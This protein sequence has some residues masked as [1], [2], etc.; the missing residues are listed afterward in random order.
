MTMNKKAVQLSINFIVITI[1]SLLVLGVGFYV[2]TNI[3]TTAYEYQDKLNEQTKEATLAALRQSGELVSLPLNKY[4]IKRGEMDQ[5]AIGLLNNAGSS[6]TFYPSIE[7]TEA[8]DSDENELCAKT[9]GISCES[10]ATAYC[11]QWITLGDEKLTLENRKDE[12]IGAFV[13]VPDNAPSG[14]FGYS[15]KVCTGNYC[16]ST[17]S[18]QYGPTKKMYIIVP[19]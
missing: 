18:T 15:F 13:A 11:S 2:V 5:F 4:T 17:G 12:A 9:Q 19:E 7:C 10:E 1:L 16:G 3:F 6:Q 8:L 14:T